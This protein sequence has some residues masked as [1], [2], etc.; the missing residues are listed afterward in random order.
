MANITDV[1]DGTFEAEVLKS[2]LPVVV[3]F[4]A[5]W[6][7]PCMMMGPIV[8]ALAAKLSGKIKFVKLNTDENPPN[9]PEIQDLGHTD[10]DRFQGRCR[11]RAADRSQTPAT[12]GKAAPGA[13]PSLFPGRPG[14]RQLTRG[15]TSEVDPCGPARV[16]RKPDNYFN[17]NTL[18]GFAC[19]FHL[20]G[21][22][23]TRMEP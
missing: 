7:G 8:E 23:F 12:A 13:Y 1:T 15:G 18:S 2:A 5:P 14:K 6:C 4:W 22:Y 19:F 20:S 3:D 16:L 21:Q 9:R 10:S 11:G 17:F